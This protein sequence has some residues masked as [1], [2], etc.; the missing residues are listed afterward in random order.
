MGEIIQFPGVNKP[1]ESSGE[2]ILEIVNR[3]EMYCDDIFDDVVFTLI[4]DGYDVTSDDYIIDISMA[5]EAIKSVMYKAE[6]LHHPI[7]DLSRTMY[8]LS[9]KYQE[10]SEEQLEF[11]F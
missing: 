8:N 4:E 7:Q 9:L 3:I 5:Y 6:K 2:D 11:D 1:T 10:S